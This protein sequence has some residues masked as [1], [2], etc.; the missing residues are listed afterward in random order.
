MD[1]SRTGASNWPFYAPVR[2]VPFVPPRNAKIQKVHPEFASPLL[3]GDSDFQKFQERGDR[4]ILNKPQAKRSDGE[5]QG[6]N[7]GL[8]NLTIYS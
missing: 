5:C 4:K 6:Q 1:I 7:S 8:T 3:K 2:I